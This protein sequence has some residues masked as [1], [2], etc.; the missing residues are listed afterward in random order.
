MN[1]RITLPLLVISFLSLDMASGAVT[2]FRFRAPF[3]TERDVEGEEFEPVSSTGPGNLRVTVTGG[4]LGG[5]P[6]ENDNAHAVLSDW[7]LG[8]NGDVSAGEDRHY[9]TRRTH[10]S[11]N[12]PGEVLRL[13]F[14]DDKGNPRKVQLTKVLFTWVGAFEKFDLAI[15]GKDIDVPAVFGTDEIYKLRPRCHVPGLVLFPDTLPFGT[16]FEFIARNCGD[17]WNIENVEV[18]PE[19]STLLIW[20]GLG[21]GG[22]GLAWRRR[23]KRIRP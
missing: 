13:Q 10:V 20:A 4:I 16:T 23:R 19:P 8:V 11:K 9:F 12:S 5:T 18:I 14:S 21:I 3:N 17:A 22:V 6:A 7:G 15:D 1:L 2:D